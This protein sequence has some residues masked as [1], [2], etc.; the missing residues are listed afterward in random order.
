[1]ELS[2]TDMQITIWATEGDIQGTIAT[3][4]L[5]KVFPIWNFV[6]LSGEVSGDSAEVFAWDIIQGRRKYIAKFDFIRTTY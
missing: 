3:G 4:E 5:C 6:L 1:M 2:N